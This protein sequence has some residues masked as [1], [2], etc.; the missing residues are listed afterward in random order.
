M[1]QNTFPKLRVP[2]LNTEIL[3]IFAF[4]PAVAVHIFFCR[5]MSLLLWTGFS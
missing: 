4:L 1:E 3:I 2:E 5:E